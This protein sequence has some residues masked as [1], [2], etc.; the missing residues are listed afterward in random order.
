MALLTENAKTPADITIADD[1]CIKLPDGYHYSTYENEDDGLLLTIRTT[2]DAETWEIRRSESKVEGVEDLLVIGLTGD[3]TR[4]FVLRHESDM[5]IYCQLH[6]LVFNRQ[7]V[8]V[9][10]IFF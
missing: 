3:K 5:C 4:E 10:H 6:L 8:A 9:Q 2:D 1:W 7:R